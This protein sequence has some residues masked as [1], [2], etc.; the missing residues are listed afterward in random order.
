[1]A[2]NKFWAALIMAGVAWARAHYNIDLGIDEPT[3]T[4]I[5]GA[6]T[7]LVVFAVPNKHRKT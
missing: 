5:V 2:Y 6:I 3:A 7:A 4:A 1:M